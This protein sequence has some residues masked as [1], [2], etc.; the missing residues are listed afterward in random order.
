MAYRITRG[1][2]SGKELK[3]I[4]LEET[5]IARRRLNSQSPS[6]TEA[7]HK[8]RQGLKRARA[9]VGLLRPASK[10]FYRRVNKTLRDLGRMLSAY[11][12]HDVMVATIDRVISGRPDLANDEGAHAGVGGIREWAERRRT[13][14]AAEFEPTIAEFNRRMAKL[15]HRLRRHKREAVPMR[16]VIRVVH[17][18]YAGLKPMLESAASEERAELYHESRKIAQRVL[19]QT[20]LLSQVDA[21]WVYKRRPLMRTLA[22]ELGYHQDLCVLED[23]CVKDE[24]ELSRIDGVESI[25]E[26]IGAEKTR[27]RA[28][29]DEL[30]IRL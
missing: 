5:A 22:K 8:A 17:A 9:V 2:P 10:S 23:H 18:D 28:R 29:I 20:A 12:D 21:A 4:A 19:N 14:L 24:S 1:Q 3:R 25:L 7:V 16:D 26:L 6:R 11:R 15:R 13:K 27:V 30:A